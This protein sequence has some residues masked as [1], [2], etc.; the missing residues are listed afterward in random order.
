MAG[1]MAWTTLCGLFV[2]A[3]SQ[4]AAAGDGY[5]T[6]PQPQKQFYFGVVGGVDLRDNQNLDGA[7]P[8][9]AVRNIEVEYDNGSMFGVS[10]GLLG[11]D[12]SWGRVRGDVEFAYRV[13][14]VEY[15]AL[16]G[17]ARVVQDGSKTE[18]M[19]GLVN[20]YYD[21]PLYFDRIRFSIGAG[22]GIA[23]VNHGINYLVA[24]AAAIGAQPGNLQIALPSSETTYAWQISGGTEIK[25]TDMISLVGD[26]RYLEINDV[27]VERYVGNSIINGVATTQGTLDS[28]LKTDLSTV[29]V[30]GGLR[31]AF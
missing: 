7:T 12:Y 3:I 24:N 1:R 30:T 29:T 18:I 9:G 8:G 2:A 25:L 15:L 11:K 31:I 4:T 28:I 14:D 6:Q 27:Q 13:S 5:G 26:V 16:N 21:T 10:V 20:A 22:F 23:N 17:I 19:T